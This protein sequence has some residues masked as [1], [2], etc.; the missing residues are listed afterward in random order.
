[1]E[2]KNSDV[3]EEI[4]YKYKI[5]E[6]IGSGGEGNAFLV[7]EKET[8][9]EYVAKVPKEDDESIV[10]E[11][12]FLNELKKYN[13]PYIIKMINSGVGDIIR[14]KRKTKKKKYLVLEKATY[15]NIYDY[16]YYYIFYLHKCLGEQKG[17]LLFSK[18][19]EGVQCMHNH[20]ICHRD[21]KLENI[22]FDDDFNPKICDFGFAC[23]NSPKITQYIG[24]KEYQPPEINENKPYD[25]FKNDIFC[26]GA[27][28]MILVTGKAAFEEAKT[29]DQLY[30]KIYK[31]KNINY[32][33]TVEPL[34]EGIKLSPEFKD[35]LI[36][37]IQ[38]NPKLRPDINA[39]LK[40]PWFKE[41]E[42]MKKNNLEKLKQ[43]EE[44]T[45]KIFTDLF[46]EVKE[47]NQLDL[48]DDNKKS[49]NASYN[50]RG[51]KNSQIKSIFDKDLEPKSIDIPINMKNTIK[52]KG[53][54]N[55]VKFMDCLCF[56][57]DN[58]FGNDNC[59]IAP[60][61]DMLKF[62]VTF[63]EDEDEEEN[64]DDEEEEDKKEEDKE[65][66]KEEEKDNKEGNEFTIQ[67]KLYKYSDEYILRFIQKDGTRKNFL[68]KF[69]II[70]KLVK[71]IIS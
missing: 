35:L 41:I 31:E 29:T 8:N 22:L 20:N 28:L 48:E 36:Q 7:K 12:T 19:L 9:I 6:K 13:N 21:I 57:I 17:K 3:Q 58:K 47:N 32:W 18:I 53:S 54:L 25:G 34:L 46:Q 63:S 40:H 38:Y 2:E 11:I 49:E 39:I 50:T 14:I 55:P 37:M 16:I 10:N 44:D 56:M 15:G 27:S 23:I 30:K 68:D 45:K 67:I 4:D 52:I 66:K 1:M 60:S 51:I 5:E 24:T 65:D 71:E 59:F 64:N 26:L 69:I 43:I 70:S 42:N 62:D 61:R 33:K